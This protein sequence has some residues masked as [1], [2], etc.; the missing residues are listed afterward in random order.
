MAEKAKS[1]KQEAAKGKGLKKKIGPLP[2]WG[3]IVGA[4]VFY[5]VY[6]GGLLGGLTGSSSTTGA[7]PSTGPAGV[8][9]SSGGANGSVPG[10]GGSGN[11]PPFP[12]SGANGTAGT[13]GGPGPMP[14]SSSKPSSSSNT[15]TQIETTPLQSLNPVVTGSQPAPSMTVS[16]GSTTAQPGATS[17]PT[18][19]T[20]TAT[21]QGIGNRKVATALQKRGFTLYKNVGGKFFAA[22]SPAAKASTN[23]GLFYNPAQTGVK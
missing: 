19:R 14:S 5:E 23:K 9:V 6:K 3:W 15:T 13:L 8:P 4:I 18:Y 21:Y 1:A 17:L 12:S 16:R 2:L 11:L 7:A 22:G 20:G 10:G